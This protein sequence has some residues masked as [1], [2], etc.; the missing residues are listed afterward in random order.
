VA[1]VSITI[2][3]VNDAPTVTVN[4][5]AIVNI[6]AGNVYADAGATADDAE[7]GDISANIVV[8]GD[9]VDTNTPGEY[10]ITYDVTDSGGIAATQ[11]T[12]TVIVGTNNPPVITL[13]GNAAIS[14]T[15]GDAYADAGATAV[16]DEDGD[17][18]AAIVVG[19]DVVN[20]A[21][22][23]TYRVTYNVTDLDGNA[24]AEVTRTVTVSNP[25]PPPPKKKSGGGATGLLE[26]FGLGFVGMVMFR[27]RR[28]RKLLA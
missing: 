6:V 26:L 12:R 16:D 25:P 7:D 21:A 27:R 14:L 13:L 9:A 17:L 10:V 8:G 19:G 11:A 2:S 24:A 5:A 1:T 15:T 20:T 28:A 18:T 22:A 3:P 23:G 4:G